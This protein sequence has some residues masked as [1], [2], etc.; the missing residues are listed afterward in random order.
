MV[1]TGTILIIPQYLETD[2]SIKQR[3][4]TI[5]NNLKNYVSFADNVKMLSVCHTVQHCMTGRLKNNELE[6]TGE[7][8]WPIL[9]Y[10]P[11]ICLE[12]LIK[13]IKKSPPGHSVSVPK[14]EPRTS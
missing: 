4:Y 9:R 7:W 8:L 1:N 11:D 5:N 14:S 2:E 3:V 13:T 6:R 12:Q 10:Y